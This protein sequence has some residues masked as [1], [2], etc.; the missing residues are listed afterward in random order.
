M[1]KWAVRIDPT[2]RSAISTLRGGHK[3]VVCESDGHLWVSGESDA[4]SQQ[5]DLHQVEDPAVRALPGK[6]YSVMNDGQLLPAGKTVPLGYLPD[7]TWLPINEWIVAELPV[8]QWASAKPNPIALTLTRLQSLS[9][10]ANPTGVSVSEPVAGTEPGVAGVGPKGNPGSSATIHGPST[11]P[12]PR[13]KITNEAAGEKRFGDPKTGD[14]ESGASLAKRAQSSPG[15]PGDL[16]RNLDFPGSASHDTKTLRF[17][18]PH[19]RG[20]RTRIPSRRFALSR[21]SLRP[22]QTDESLSPAI[23]CRRFVELVTSS[24]L[25][26][27][28]RPVCPGPRPFLRRSPEKRSVQNRV[29]SFGN[30]TNVGNCF[31]PT[32]WST[33]PARLFEKPSRQ[34]RQQA[35]PADDRRTIFQIREKPVFPLGQ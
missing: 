19:R 3:V 35:E 14:T 26:L 32:H 28:S 6:H 5:A 8:S 34:F 13:N 33:P 21:C 12:T 27:P 10:P 31:Q 29:S 16:E 18:R 23:R 30:R 22:R 1:T 11:E 24:N 2:S 15:H 9:Q 7:S 20:W 4:P 17:S 25:K